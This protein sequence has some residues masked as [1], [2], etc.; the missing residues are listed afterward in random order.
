MGT[1]FDRAAADRIDNA[2]DDVS[3]TSAR[4]R[5]KAKQ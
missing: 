4:R 3:M 5:E 1:P 2:D